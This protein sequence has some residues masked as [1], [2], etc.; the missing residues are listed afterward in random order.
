MKFVPVALAAGLSLAGVTGNRLHVEA[1]DSTE[2]V[3]ELYFLERLPAL[4]FL[5]HKDPKYFVV[6][7][8]EFKLAEGIV[9]PT[10]KVGFLSDLSLEK[11]GKF[12]VLR[13]KSEYPFKHKLLYSKEQQRYR[14]VLVAESASAG[15]PPTGAEEKAPHLYSLENIV[16]DGDA[17]ALEFRG[18]PPPSFHQKQLPLEADILQ[19]EFAGVV[20]EPVGELA[21]QRDFVR[22]QPEASG[23]TCSI[24]LKST[25]LSSRNLRIQLKGTPVSEKMVTLEPEQSAPIPEVSH[26]QPEVIEEPVE[27]PA[28]P[29]AEPE[30]GTGR[31][32]S[33]AV[34][35]PGEPT[36]APFSSEGVPE[37]T[38]EPAVVEQPVPTEAE[39]SE[40]PAQ[41]GVEEAIPAEE[42]P[43]PQRASEPPG[44]EPVPETPLESAVSEAPAGSEAMP[45]E[46]PA[47][48]VEESTTPPA[49]PPAAAPEAPAVP[50][51]EPAPPGESKIPSDQPAEE[52]KTPTLENPW[53]ATWEGDLKKAVYERKPDGAEVRLSF[54]KVCNF[55]AQARVNEVRITALD[56]LSDF[57]VKDFSG[58]PVSRIEIG[59][60]LSGV[61]IV[62]SLREGIDA[63]LAASGND[64]ILRLTEAKGTSEAGTRTEP[65]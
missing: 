12:V 57:F 7:F 17:V 32:T 22:C 51:P 31:E 38:E 8:E 59:P 6:G 64:L 42:A 62:I 3:I 52:S 11:D 40:P 24:Y 65:K 34:A 35:E 19:I 39:T 60:D 41:S 58:G 13:A 18:K 10:E 15:P 1:T 46:E 26:P 23:T 56:V 43:A 28:P 47:P 9:F 49:G 36:P 45:L 55:V 37:T 63:R 50:A 21:A 61:L 53:T 54:S 33:S 20:V 16:F 4:M 14:V 5:S 2:V 25:R 44:A 29:L 48:Q 27:T 30:E